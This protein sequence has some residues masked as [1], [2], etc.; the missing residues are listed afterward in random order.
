MTD[1]SPSKK[2]IQIQRILVPTDFSP[3]AD[4]AVEVAA[5]YAR[6][7]NAHLTV[8]HVMPPFFS[9][10]EADI[11]AVSSAYYGRELIG[12]MEGN[13]EKV[14]APL[15]E[16]GISVDINLPHGVPAI[17]VV[18]LARQ[19]DTDLIVVSTHGRTGLG[20]AFLGSTAERIVQKASCPVLTVR[21]Q[22]D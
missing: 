10:T 21:P 9:G 3:L 7:F 5:E 13:L 22:A 11:F 18:K 1:P 8:V 20:H 19:L 4:T 12:I 2:E 17:E 15:R 6:R 16:Q 14:A